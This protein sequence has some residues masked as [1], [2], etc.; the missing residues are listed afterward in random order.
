V[1]IPNLNINGFLPHGLHRCSLQEVEVAFV[2]QFQSSSSRKQLMNSLKL[3]YAKWKAFP[4]FD[5]MVLDGSFVTNKE[6]PN[7]IDLIVVLKPSVL[8]DPMSGAFVGQMSDRASIKHQYSIDAFPVIDEGTEY[9]D[10]VSYFIVDR[11]S[12]VRGLLVIG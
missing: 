4:H 10:W 8:H 2:S 11:Q 1:P 5:R 12:N 3:F 6:N 9:N 7:D